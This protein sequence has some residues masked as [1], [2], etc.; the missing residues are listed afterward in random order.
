[1]H[2]KIRTVFTISF[3]LIALQVSAQRW[4]GLRS[5]SDTTDADKQGFVLLPL[6]Y[7]TPDTRLAYGA[8]GVYYFK[9]PGQNPEG[10]DTRLSY[11]QLLVDYTQNQQLDIWGIWNVFTPGEKYLLKGELRFRNFPDR[12]YGLGNNTPTENMER[13]AY[14][15]LS[16]KALVMRNLKNYWFAGGD[17]HYTYEYNFSRAANGILDQ[18]NITGYDGGT[19]VGIGAVILFDNRDNVINAYRGQLFELSSYFYE[20]KLGS[21]FSFVKIDG[22]FQHYRQVFPKHILAFQTAARF[23]FGEVPFLDMNTV[24]GLDLLRGY[25]ANRFRDHNFVGTQVEYRFPIWKRFGGVAFTGVGDVFQQPNQLRFDLL[26][27]SAGAGIRFAMNPA[28]R[29]NIRLD[30]AVGRGNSAF[31]IMVSESF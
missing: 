20:K 22:V 8:A 29:L 10:E 5:E 26:K 11:T 6:L 1:M 14:D 16:F 9:L 13:Y 19:G 28:E 27:Y 4:L 3:L 23:A 2:A 18:G 30:Y 12:F 24:G 21:S 7:Y 15:L 25:A 17:I 31:Y